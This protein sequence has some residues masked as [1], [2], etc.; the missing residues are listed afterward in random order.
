M[1][2]VPTVV[3]YFSQSVIIQEMHPNRYKKT[4]RLQLIYQ[5]KLSGDIFITKINLIW[6][7]PGRNRIYVILDNNSTNHWFTSLDGE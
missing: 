5:Y 1:I 7:R 4:F 3:V 6:I 2:I